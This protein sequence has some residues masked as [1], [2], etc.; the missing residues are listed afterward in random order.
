MKSKALL[1]TLS[2]GFLLAVCFLSGCGSQTTEP[3]STAS[4]ATEETEES[5]T[6]DRDWEPIETKY[7]TL[8]YPDQ[9]FDYLETEQSESGDKLIV[10]FRAAIGEQKIDLFELSVGG[11]DGSAAGK[12]TGPD[13]VSRDVFV[14]LLELPELS[15]LT[16]GETNRVYAMQEAVNDVIDYLS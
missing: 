10:L 4:E 5:M 16:D 3:G 11:G 6:P 8:C 7:G 1:L 9:W 12:L 13:G 2:L 15:G 14:K